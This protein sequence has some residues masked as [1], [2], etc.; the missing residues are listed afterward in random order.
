MWFFIGPEAGYQK[1]I[2]NKGR[3][4]GRQKEFSMRNPIIRGSV[5]G[6]GHQIGVLFSEEMTN[7]GGDGDV[8]LKDMLD[9]RLEHVKGA[10]VHKILYLLKMAFECR[11]SSP[12][13]RRV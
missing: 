12:V 3:R 6:D 11:N 2:L 7:N 5:N 1:A 13:H 8:F 10:M 4:S 9:G